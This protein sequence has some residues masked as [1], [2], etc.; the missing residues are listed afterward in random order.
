[1]YI[2]AHEAGILDETWQMLDTMLPLLPN[3]KALC[4]ECEGVDGAA[5][6]DT[7]AILRNKVKNFSA[8]ADLLATLGPAS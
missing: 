2:D 1:V 4:Y 8:S 6:I 3:V 7:L 5:V